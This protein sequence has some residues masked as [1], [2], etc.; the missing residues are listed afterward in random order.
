MV[1]PGGTQLK[2]TGG[3][4]LEEVVVTKEK[5]AT[6]RPETA[7]HTLTVRSQQALLEEGACSTTFLE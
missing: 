7:T 6:A 4:Q 2:T 3:G 1:F 5:E